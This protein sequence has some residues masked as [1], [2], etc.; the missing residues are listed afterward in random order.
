[1]NLNKSDK[2]AS[3]SHFLKSKK[4]LKQETERSK[5][6]VVAGTALDNHVILNE[7][8]GYLSPPDLKS[9]P[10]VEVEIR[11]GSID[12]EVQKR[13]SSIAAVWVDGL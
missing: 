8:F 3:S 12:P 1:M 7:I 13:S 9:L 4:N 2:G 11:K 5:K 6:S 10:E